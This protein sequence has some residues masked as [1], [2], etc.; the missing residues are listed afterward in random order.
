MGMTRGDDPAHQRFLVM[1][2]SVNNASRQALP[3]SLLLRWQWPPHIER[4]IKQ[5]TWLEVGVTSAFDSKFHVELETMLD[6][7]T[8]HLFRLIASY[9]ES[10][11]AMLD[12]IADLPVTS[13]AERVAENPSTMPSTLAK[14]AEHPDSNVKI[15]VACNA[16]TPS[17]AVRKLANDESL[18]VRYAIA[19]NANSSYELLVLLCQDENCYVA[20][21]AQRTILRITPKQP[22]TS[23]SNSWW[24]VDRSMTQQRRAS[25]GQ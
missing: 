13:L 7:M 17:D 11:A 6:C 9:P 18:D 14:L 2:D 5:L 4:T 16:S 20:H 21:R 19:E 3:Y 24:T 22:L 25:Q 8:M 15:A 12:F 1:Q 10:P 23:T